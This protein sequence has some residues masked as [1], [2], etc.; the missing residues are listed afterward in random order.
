MTPRES[1]LLKRQGTLGSSDV[2]YVVLP[3]EHWPVKDGGPV[4]VWESK[5]LPLLPDDAGDPSDPR[6]VGSYMEC[7]IAW[8][9]ADDLGA[10][11]VRVQ[12]VVGPEPWMAATADY[13]LRFPDGHVEGLE[14]KFVQDY[15]HVLAWSASEEEAPPAPTV[16][17]L[18]CRVCYGAHYD[19]QRWNIAV[20]LVPGGFRRYV[21][22]R[23][24]AFEAAV[25]DRCRAWWDRYVVTTTMPP[26]DDTESSYRVIRRVHGL[27]SDTIRRAT[28]GEG[29]LIVGWREAERVLRAAQVAHDLA[30]NRLTCAVGPDLGV[31][32]AGVG[33]FTWRADKNGHRRPHFRPWRD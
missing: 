18:W 5:V 8:W 16:Q 17:S 9:A 22:E 25:V 21:Y 15:G 20:C 11:L 2:P 32:A 23:D 12:G 6:T 4:K 26:V 10:E 19:I 33:T 7:S 1:W 31:R 14:C 27:H 29:Q 30:F 28:D 24:D 3:A 13:L